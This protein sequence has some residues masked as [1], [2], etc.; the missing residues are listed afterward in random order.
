MK[1]MVAGYYVDTYKGVT[2]TVTKVEGHAAWYWM[3]GNKPAEDWYS[4]KKVAVE[5]A[6]D[7][8]DNPF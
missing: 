5:A 6:K 3:I 2:F 8:I 1:K 7:Y 4:S